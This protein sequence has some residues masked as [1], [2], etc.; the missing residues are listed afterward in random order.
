MSNNTKRCSKCGQEKDMA[1][2][3]RN[4]QQKSGRHPSC[5][6]CDRGI[7]KKWRDKDIKENPEKRKKRASEWHENNKSEVSKRHKIDYQTK[8]NKDSYRNKKYLRLYNITIDDYNDMFIC[9]AGKCAIC[10][11]HQSDLKRRLFIDHC[12]KTGV[13][14]GLL[15][16]RCNSA[17][18][19]FLDNPKTVSN[20][21][22]YLE[23]ESAPNGKELNYL[24]VGY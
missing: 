2:Y 23:L 1:C 7:R 11:V 6:E 12:H 14:R 5:K 3:D 17:L 22:K 24:A 20:A 21:L 18:G 9:Q 19:L 16:H 4:V 13:V 10:G 15:C 8:K